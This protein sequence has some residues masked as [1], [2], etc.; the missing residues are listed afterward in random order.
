MKRKTFTAFGAQMRADMAALS[1]KIDRDGA[2]LSKRDD[3]HDLDMKH[4]DVRLTC[5]QVN[6]DGQFEGYG[7]VFGNEDSYGDVVARGAFSESLDAHARAGT[8]PALLWQHDPRHPI[9]VYTEMRE[10][11]RGLYV[12]GQLALETQLGREAHA[13]LKA[14]ALNGLSIG[15]MPK[16][17]QIDE[18]TGVLTLLEVDLWECSVVT[19]PANELARVSGVKMKEHASSLASWKAFETFLRDEG[20]FSKE[21]AAAMAASARRIRDNEREARDTMAQLQ[22]ANARLLDL[23]N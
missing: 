10:D 7:S 11:D 18:D 15:Y 3:T 17:Y 1:Q 14:G 16:R 21:T 19:F 2:P 23:L 8:M 6:E 13:L 4:Q 12:K 22:D 20:G 9:G 5:K